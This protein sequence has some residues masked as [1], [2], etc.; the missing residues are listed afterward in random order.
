MISY[1]SK[2]SAHSVE[3]LELD[4]AR[5]RRRFARFAAA[6]EAAPP[7]TAQMLR[8]SM[9]TPKARRTE[10]RRR[11]VPGLAWLGLGS[12]ALMCGGLFVSL[13]LW[14]HQ[15]AFDAY[16]RQPGQTTVRATGSD[17]RKAEL[18]NGDRK[19]GGSQLLPDREGA[20]ASQ[21]RK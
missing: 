20:V 16:V 4:L 9:P 15:D 21:L 17:V 7:P 11:P 8:A 3:A 19:P 14:R 10:L 18:R 6:M 13:L 1:S 5:R 2:P 12:W